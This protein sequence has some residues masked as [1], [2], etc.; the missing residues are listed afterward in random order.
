MKKIKGFTLVEL[1]IVIAII[2]ILAAIVIVS[3]NEAKKKARDVKRIAELKTVQNALE[4]Y[5]DEHDEYPWQG[6]KVE[7]FPFAGAKHVKWNRS[8]TDESGSPVTDLD[9]V[10]ASAGFPLAAF[11][12]DLPV[13]PI[14][15]MVGPT[16][17]AYAYASLDGSGYKIIAY[18]MESGEGRAKA[19]ND[20]GKV[21]SGITIWYELFSSNAQWYQ[22]CPKNE[23]PCTYTFP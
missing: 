12:R 23:S 10:G 17:Y 13:D 9:W 15:R 2:G 5:Y 11:V 20:G 3:V 4:M 8:D 22:D 6:V 1:L 16:L 19:Q 14:N 7:S 21:N 18:N